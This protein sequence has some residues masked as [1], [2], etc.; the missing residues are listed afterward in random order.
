MK[1]ARVTTWAPTGLDCQEVVVEVAARPGLSSFS[2]VGL[3]GRSVAESR[4]RV[5][6]AL[7]SIGVKLPST[8]IVI[9]LSPAEMAKNGSHYD[10]PICVALLKAMGKISSTA[11]PSQTGIVGQLGLDGSIN[12]VPNAISFALAAQNT[13]RLLLAPKDVEREVG[14]VDGLKVCTVASLDDLLTAI[15]QGKTLFKTVSF[16]ATARSPIQLKTTFNDISGQLLA[17]RV[18]TIAIAGR[19][20]LLMCGPPGVGKTMLA[21]SMASLSPPLSAKNRLA[22]TSIYSAAGLLNESIPFILEA[23]LRQPHHTSTRA[24]LLGG[25]AVPGPGEISLAHHGILF[26]DELPLFSSYIL[27]ALREPLINRQINI[28]RLSG[29]VTYPADFLL[30]GA[31][32]PCRCGYLGSKTKTCRCNPADILRYQRAL[33]GPILDRISLFIRLGDVNK[34][35]TAN[36]NEH[37]TAQENIIA[38]KK[39]QCARGQTVANG[40]LDNKQINELLQEAGLV[41]FL[42]DKIAAQNISMRRVYNAVRVAQTIADLEGCDLNKNHINEAFA[43]LPPLELEIS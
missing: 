24:S 38:A 9:N 28:N 34:L 10:L 40:R 20:H 23:P 4:E 18:A 1:V 17:K 21:E 19:H 31:F 42:E 35:S 25:G 7:R 43:L 5:K 11:I 3:A 26:M 37:K 6:M 13:D 41:S 12:A 22:V 16:N 30:V 32:N 39:R 33:S 2:I 8:S 15:E 36:V 14:L 27:E 29:R